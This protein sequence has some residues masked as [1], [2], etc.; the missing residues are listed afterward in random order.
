METKSI[1][2]RKS[3]ILF[4]ASLAVI[5]TS[6]ALGYIRTDDLHLL[7]L[8]IATG[9]VLLIPPV[10]LHR[11]A[12]PSWSDFLLGVYWGATLAISIVFF[13]ATLLSAFAAILAAVGVLIYI[14]DVSKTRAFSL[15]RFLIGSAVGFALIVPI[16]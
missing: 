16:I 4:V 3:T 12:R 7:P 14:G 6:L 15:P 10:I 11:G 8:T 9:V 1:H 13:L 5:L 2:L